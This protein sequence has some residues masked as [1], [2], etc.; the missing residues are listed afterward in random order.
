MPKERLRALL[1]AG[2]CSASSLMPRTSPQ[3]TKSDADGCHEVCSVTFKEP[4]DAPHQ[5]IVPNFGGT[6]EIMKEIIDQGLGL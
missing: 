4:G 2:S 6:T 5:S 1:S 3:V